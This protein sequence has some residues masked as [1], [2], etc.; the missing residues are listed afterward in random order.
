MNCPSNM[1]ISRVNRR[2]VEI[3]LEGDMGVIVDNLCELWLTCEDN[4]IKITILSMPKKQGV[5]AGVGLESNRRGLVRRWSHRLESWEKWASIV[6]DWMPDLGFIS[7]CD[8]LG[9]EFFFQKWG[10]GKAIFFF[11]ESDSCR[12]LF[13][14][15]ERV[16]G[17]FMAINCLK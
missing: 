7:G 12:F 11:I 15:Q 3:L 6:F 2:S 10:I 9:K 14:Y 5:R 13:K 1:A 8:L 16:C 4:T 17:I